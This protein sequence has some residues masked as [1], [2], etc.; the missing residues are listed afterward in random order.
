MWLP[1]VSTST[2]T[3]NSASAT[4]IVRPIPP[5]RF[6]PLA[7][8]KSIERCSRSPGTRAST[9]SRP[10]L[11]ITS[12]I[13]NTRHAPAGRGALPFAGLP[14]RTRPAARASGEVSD[15]AGR[16]APACVR[17]GC[18]LLGV[19]DRAGLPDDRDLDL[20]RVGQLLLDLLDDVAR[21]ACRG[22]VVDLF[23]SHED[24]DLAPGLDRERLL[25]S[26][27]ALGDR[28]EI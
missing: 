13:I 4:L 21:E 1:E 6:S 22:E 3:A 8:T 2:P 24:A 15:I 17:D 9:A 14:S 19:F 27:E 25:H 28:L 26:A 18:C 11:P 7:V 12:P 23:G 16:L 10:G 5:A 20:A